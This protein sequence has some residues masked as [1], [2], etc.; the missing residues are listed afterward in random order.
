MFKIQK[1]T[2]TVKYLTDA[3]FAHLQNKLSHLDKEAFI[4]YIKDN[5]ISTKDINNG[6]KTFENYLAQKNNHYGAKFSGGLAELWNLDYSKETFAKLMAAQFPKSKEELEKLHGFKLKTTGK[7]IN[8]SD[9]QQA[10]TDLLTAL[11]KSIS[12]E[13]ARSGKD[14]RDK[15]YNATEKTDNQ[16]FE[17][18]AKQILPSCKKGEYQEF[19][20]EKTKIFVASFTH[21]EDRGLDPHLHRHHSLMNFAEFEFLD[22]TKKILAIDPAVA[23]KCQLENSA[24][25]DTLLNSNIQKEGFITESCET[26][27]GHK[28]FRIKGYTREQELL[29]SKRKVEIKEF[30]KQQ[31]KLGNY[32]SSSDEAES[33]YDS[34]YEEAIQKNTAKGKITHNC[35]EILSIIK[36]ESEINISVDEFA[37]IDKVQNES[38]QNFNNADLLKLMKSQEFETTGVITE[39]KLRT[40]VIK[41]VR[42]TKIF[43]N[44]EDL[45]NEVDKTILNMSSIAMGENRLIKMSNGEFTRLDIAVNEKSVLNNI[46]WLK[47]TTREISSIDEKLNRKYLADFLREVNNQV[48]IDPKENFKFNEGQIEACKLIIKEKNVS[49][50]VGDAGSGKTSTVIKFTSEFYKN[51]N[52][53]VFG[54]STGTATSKD[55]MTANI[56]SENCLN[57]KQFIN[58]AFSKDTGE[59]KPSFLK[60]NY[61]SVLILD[62]AGM[63]GSEDYRKITDW[64]KKS[65]SKIVL[66]GDHKQLTAVSYGNSFIAIQDL[67]DKSEIS[68]LDENCRQRNQ[69]AKDIAEGYRDK[70]IEKVFKTLDKEGWLIT[71]K[72]DRQIAEALCKDYLE[73]KSHSKLIICGVNTE[74]DFINDKVRTEFIKQ[75]IQKE[76]LDKSYTSNLDY[77]NS[78]LITVERRTGTHTKSYDRNFCKGDEIVFLENHK[79]KEERFQ[80]FNSNKGLIKNIEPLKDGNF[81][82]TVEVDKKTISFSTKDYKKFN[83]CFAIS[84]HKSQGKTVKNTY[85]LGNS[86]TSNNKSYVDGSRHKDTYKLYLKED[87]VEKFKRNSMKEQIK[88]T[89]INDDNCKTAVNDYIKS[90]ASQNRQAA[91]TPP[92]EFI[93]SIDTQEL[94]EKAIRAHLNQKSEVEQEM[95]KNPVVSPFLQ[96][97]SKEQVAEEIARKLVQK[98]KFPTPS[99]Y[100]GPKL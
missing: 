87:E 17:L 13:F 94:K 67:L 5:G 15:I 33:A 8:S 63:I 22:G 4:K 76:K 84:S 32:F 59:I 61:G 34:A 20:P 46:D 71:A 62:E 57:T 100:K 60:E 48:A 3:E 11:P 92:K 1:S 81:Q 27:E 21:Y 78:Q 43:D 19:N 50:I 93:K 18:L 42:F 39:T 52:K 2:T 54:I 44:A 99:P 79:D 49:V 85:H 35:D 69:S 88:E 58:N 30:V 77:K 29:L 53:K 7:F 6:T 70:D 31:K 66:V 83:H 37:K 55:M 24:F 25:Y 90:K 10:G 65:S 74:I 28:T 26:E 45:N 82:L 14:K 38:K 72:T 80:V 16:M 75:E 36:A 73:D 41:A 91:P 95:K 68:R 64:A 9:K 47:S 96:P 97:K 89:T 86:F 40:A 56:G 23:F 51:K 98:P 12:V